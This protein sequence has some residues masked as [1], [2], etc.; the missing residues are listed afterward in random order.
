VIKNNSKWMSFLV[1]ALIAF[2]WPAYMHQKRLVKLDRMAA[3]SAEHEAREAAIDNS[4]LKDSRI[5]LSEVRAARRAYEVTMCGEGDRYMQEI[6]DANGGHPEPLNQSN[7]DAERKVCAD[8]L[9]I[10]D[11]WDRAEWVPGVNGTPVISQENLRALVVSQHATLS[12]DQETLKATIGVVD[13]DYKKEQSEAR[14]Q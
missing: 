12:A 10:L 9:A 4:S 11:T 7:Y 8:S 13:K 3:I 5:N 2:V 14:R 1:F 6:S